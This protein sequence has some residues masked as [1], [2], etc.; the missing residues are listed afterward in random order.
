MRAGYWARFGGSGALNAGST[1]SIIVRGYDVGGDY[2]SGSAIT[3]ASVPGNSITSTYQRISGTYTAPA[4]VRTVTAQV[5]VQN[6]SAG[7]LMVDDVFLEPVSESLAD[8]FARY[9]LAV[10]AGG[11]VAGMQLLAGGGTSAI[12]F[13][14]ETV[15]FYSS[16]GAFEL[17]N[18]R[19][20]SRSNGYMRVEGK[21]FGS[22]GDLL[23]WYGPEQTNLNNCTKAN[24]LFW[25]DNNGDGYFAGRVMQGVLRWFQA[26]QS[27]SGTASTSTGNN[28]RL[29][30]SVSLT[31]K[32]R[33]G[34]LYTYRGTGA[35]VTPGSGNTRVTVHIERRYGSGAWTELYSETITGSAEA[36]NEP[37]TI[38]TWSVRMQGE[39]Y[40]TDTASSTN[41]EYRARI[42][43]R[44]LQSHTGSGQ[45]TDPVEVSQYLSIEAME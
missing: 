35:I 12:R 11:D 36:F 21:P 24:G 10:T 38:A 43:S 16:D 40:A 44:S 27:T 5:R 14:S 45:I 19:Q 32:Y 29:G 1:V 34:A 37:N 17:A 6:Q 42:S 39:F 8:V 41:S 28:P 30:K 31:V 26:T 25:L 33:Y 7:S 20:I 15:G 9:S 18:G 13:L 2:V 22:T 23:S 4:N 3:V